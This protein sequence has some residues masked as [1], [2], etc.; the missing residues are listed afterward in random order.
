MEFK[1]LDLFSG[2]GGFS[3]GLDFLD[4]YETVLA[5]DNN[6]H[7]IETFSHNFPNAKTIVGDILL[8]TVKKEIID[9]AKNLNVNMIIGG[10][11]CQGFSNKGKKL[12]LDDPRNFLFLEYLEVVEKLKPE[13]FII[14]NVK[15]MVTAANGYFMNE[16]QNKIESLG[17]YMTCSILNSKNYGVPQSRERAFI[18]SLIHI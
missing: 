7:A 3:C 5:V 4:N 11:P 2:A 6:K 16:I 13:I 8:D 10:P 15:S 18:L 14:E 9:S 12:G 1:I 17:Y